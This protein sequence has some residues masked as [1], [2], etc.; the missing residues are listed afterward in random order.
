MRGGEFGAPHLHYPP[1]PVCFA[2]V[3]VNGRRYPAAILG[4]TEV[5]HVRRTLPTPATL[6][7]HARSR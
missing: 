6:S 1:T 3:I 7:A 2:N 4:I 5:A